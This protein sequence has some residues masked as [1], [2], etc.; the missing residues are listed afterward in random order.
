MLKRC[1][2]ETVDLRAPASMVNEPFSLLFV[3]VTVTTG[4]STLGDVVHSSSTGRTCLFCDAHIEA[5]SQDEQRRSID[6]YSI[7]MREGECCRWSRRNQPLRAGV[8]PGLVKSGS[9]WETTNPC[10]LGV[11]PGSFRWSVIASATQAGYEWHTMPTGSGPGTRI[12]N[13]RG[14]PRTNRVK[15]EPTARKDCILADEAGQSPR[16]VL[17]TA[18]IVQMPGGPSLRRV[19]LKLWRHNRWRARPW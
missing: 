13:P 18:I 16:R 11:H 9:G 10:A 17:G 6:Y 12:A 1:L 14:S 5:M 2:A 4:D 3:V 15:W 7:L 8:T 19:H